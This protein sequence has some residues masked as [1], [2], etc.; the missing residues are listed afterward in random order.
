MTPRVNKSWSYGL[1]LILLVSNVFAA[2]PPVAVVNGVSISARLMERNVRANVAKGQNDTPALRAALKEELIAREL[3]VQDAL[4]LGLDKRQESEDSLHVLRQNYLIDVLVQEALNKSP[5][6]DAELK[7]EYER[8]VQALNAGNLQQYHLATIVLESEIDARNVMA[9][10]RT[11]QVFESLAREK[12]VDS[13]KVN[14]PG[15]QGGSTL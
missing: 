2:D 8:Q 14:R 10:L 11:G 13:S 12:S 7:A 15:F 6:T 4:R 3:M 1:W 5:V 9:A